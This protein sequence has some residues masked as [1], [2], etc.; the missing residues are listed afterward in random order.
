VRKT[1]AVLITGGGLLLGLAAPSPALAKTRPAP[2]QLLCSASANGGT[3][4]NGVCVLPAGVAG[5]ANTYYGIIAASNPDAGDTFTV[6]SGTVP[7]GLTVLAQYG[8]GTIVT[9]TPTQAGTFVFTVQA[10]SPQGATAALAYSITITA[11]PPDRLV[12]DASNGGTLVNGVCVLPGASVGQPYEG[13][14]ITSNNSGGTF[15]IASGSLPPGLSMP[16]SYGASGTIVAGTPTRQ[17]TFTFT[18]KGTDQQGQPLQQAY[19][20][21]VGPAPPLA[22][23]LPASGATLSP[24]QVGV[25]Y[26][27]NFSLSGGVAPYTWSV[28]SGTLPP[29]LALKTTAGPSDT[30]NQLAGTPTTAGTFVFTMK[31]TDSAGSQATQQFSLTI[32]PK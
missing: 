13:F 25:A 8:A 29:G 1:I 21:T 20:I 16:S 3:L 7:P 28:A 15:A 26:A 18:V 30:D 2:I 10:T 6:I 9:G 27:Q 24:G 23:T 5:G 32:V 17:G 22:I 19:S 31:V 14:I 4:V 11:Q 12:C